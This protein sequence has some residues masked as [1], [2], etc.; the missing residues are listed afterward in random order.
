M[1]GNELTREVYTRLKK[2]PLNFVGNVE[3]RDLFSGTV[4]VIVCDG[5]IGNVALKISEGLA[6][7]HIGLLKKALKSTLAS[8]VG[9]RAFARRLEGFRKRIDYTEYGGAPLLG[10]R[11]VSV[12]GHG[13][14]NANAIKNAIRVAADLA[15]A[16]IN[17]KIEQELSARRCGSIAAERAR[18]KRNYDG[19]T[20]ILI[21]GTGIAVP[22]H[23]P[24]AGGKVSGGP[25][26][27]RGSRQRARFF[28]FRAV[29]FRLRRRAEADREYPARDSHCFRRRLSRARG[30]GHHGR[31]SWPG[32]AW[33][34]I[35]RWSLQARLNFPTPCARC[36]SAA[37]YMQEAVP[38]GEGAM[39]AILG[40]R[41]GRGGG[42]LQGAAEGEVVAPANLNSPEQTV[43]SG[44]ADAVKRAVENRLGSAAPS[45]P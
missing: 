25:R 11:G 33:A 3:G 14:S 26:R 6:R 2:L 30:E 34:N 35:R 43:I 31:I 27:V 21:S 4:D 19:Q 45:A 32:T 36:A 40:L 5:F 8:Q 12:I 13:R 37:Q 29:L 22:R 16:R 9:L 18:R 42:C 7:A 41:P 15:R 24:G 44:H 23:G 38:A 1:K 28:D 10:V 39:A 17:E 20:R